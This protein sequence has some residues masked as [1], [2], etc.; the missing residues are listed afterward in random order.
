MRTKEKLAQVL[1]GHGL[2]G[3]E[4]AARLGEYDDFESES[5]TPI[6][7]LVRDLRAKGEDDLARRAIDGEWDATPEESE[8]WAASP[9][10]R[11]TIGKLR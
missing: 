11:E 10:G 3:L 4:K 9:E 2:L 5:A 6:A 7:D 8:A 1:H